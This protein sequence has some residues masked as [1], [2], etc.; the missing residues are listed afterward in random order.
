MMQRM[1]AVNQNRY[2]GC[3]DV[4]GWSGPDLLFAELKR[5]K[6]DRVRATQHRWLA[7]GLQ[8]GLQAENFLLVEWA[9]AG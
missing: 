9:F 8:V 3:W 1:A 2:A 7:A 5:R 4:V 6:Q